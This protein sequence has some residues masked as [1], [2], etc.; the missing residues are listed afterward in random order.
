MESSVAEK[1]ALSLLAF[2]I[3]SIVL[4]PLGARIEG[5]GGTA[6]AVM[7]GEPGQPDYLLILAE[8]QHDDD[9][10]QNN[11]D[12]AKG[13][14]IDG[15]K[16]FDLPTRRELN[17]LRANAKDKFNDDWYWSNEP[18]GSDDAWYQGFYDG[19]QNWYYQRGN[20]IRGCAV[21]RIPILR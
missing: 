13:L 5:Q 9:T 6:E 14:E 3:A 2:A 19:T 12:W 4:P 21:R 17:A 11:L 1:P 15:H 8:P 10:W 18:Y 7:K 16:D 20:D